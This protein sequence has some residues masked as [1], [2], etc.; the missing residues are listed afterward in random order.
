MTLLPAGTR[1]NPLA[2]TR[3][4]PLSPP[5]FRHIAADVR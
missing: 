3:A 1:D 5:G 2:A 4:E